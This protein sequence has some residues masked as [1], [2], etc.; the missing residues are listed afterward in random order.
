MWYNH[1]KNTYLD[2][3]LLYYDA[4]GKLV[5]NKAIMWA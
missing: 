4:E 2:D 3:I 5:V 1:L